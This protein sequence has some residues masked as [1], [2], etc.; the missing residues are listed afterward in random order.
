MPT[1]S[2]IPCV[3]TLPPG[4]VIESIE[5]RTGEAVIVFGNDTH[6]VE[7]D[8]RLVG[9]CE[10]ADDD[11][12][13]DDREVSRHRTAAGG[14]ALVFPGGC[15]EI[16]FPDPVTEPEAMALVDAIGHLTRDELRTL[17]GWTL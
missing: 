2:A 15:F 16:M 11:G 4:W 12:G 3:D 14:W 17:T 9:R 7:A 8:F 13:S 1:A 10:L 6:D 5:T